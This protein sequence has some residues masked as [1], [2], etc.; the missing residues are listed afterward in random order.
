MKNENSHI[1]LLAKDHRT[2]TSG[3]HG[4]PYFRRYGDFV[5][6]MLGGLP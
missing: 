1:F 2:M 6:E 5:K 3:G 4:A